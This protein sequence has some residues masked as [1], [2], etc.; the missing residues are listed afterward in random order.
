MRLP[1]LRGVFDRRILINYRVSPEV[2][3]PLLPAPFRPNVVCGFG[4]VGICLIRLKHI[5]PKF[6]PSWLGITSENAAHRSAV[7]WD[8]RGAV[9]E[10][11]YIRRRDTNSRFNA[12]AGG[13]LFPGSQ[14]HATFIVQET[15]D[16]LHVA[17]ESD[18]DATSMTVSGHVNCRLPAS[19]VFGSLEEASEFSR[20][21]SLG[22]SPTSDPARFEGMKLH[23]HAWRVE[24][25][26]IDVVRSSFFEDESL[27]PKGSIALDHALLMRGVEHE[28]HV[29]TD[30]C[31][32]ATESCSKQ[33]ECAHC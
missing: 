20:V 12:L 14:H 15:A 29:L 25:L 32:G 27:F 8:D 30:L 6:L 18:D 28:W 10:G 13:R 24:P 9:H 26:A 33:A 17:I 22:Y 23:C 16:R 1:V 31:C 21:G 7:Q 5:R 4:W 3:A 11:F 2:L 19:S